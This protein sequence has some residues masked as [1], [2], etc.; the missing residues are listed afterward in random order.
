MRC[1]IEVVT[2]L[3]LPVNKIAIIYSISNILIWRHSYNSLYA[4]FDSYILV[5]SQS[6][7]ELDGIDHTV[8]LLS[9]R[10][11]ANNIYCCIEGDCL[12]LF[13]TIIVQ[14]FLKSIHE[15]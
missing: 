1:K 11:K 9:S 10:L 13:I 3:M 14:T 12:F 2:L 8:S 7:K 6:L 15:S 4:A 5:K